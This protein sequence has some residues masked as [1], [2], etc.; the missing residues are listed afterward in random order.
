MYLSSLVRTNMWIC[1]FTAPYED[2]NVQTLCKNLTTFL[3]PQPKPGGNNW[4]CFTNHQLCLY[5]NHH[6]RSFR[7]T[8]H[9]SS[10]GLD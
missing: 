10:G 6:I 8:T 5:F 9:L 3:V 7:V 1:E 4:S 2:R